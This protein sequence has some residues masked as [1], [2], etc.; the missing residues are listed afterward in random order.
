M[1]TICFLVLSV[2][3]VAT[4][5]ALEDVETVPFA[6][7][8]NSV[9][10]SLTLF[11]RRFIPTTVQNMIAGFQPLANFQ[12]DLAYNG[13]S[14]TSLF[15][16]AQSTWQGIITGD[17]SD[18]GNIC[19]SDTCGCLPCSIDD[20]RICGVYLS[21]DGTGGTLG[22]AG[23]TRWRSDTLIPY[24]GEMFFDTADVSVGNV[25]SGVILHEMAHV[26]GLGT[27]W[28]QKG[29]ASS[30]S[31][32]CTYSGAKANQ[33]YQTLSGCTGAI[34]LE[35]STG[36][37]GSDCG[38]WAEACFG[39]ELM[40]PFT[41]GLTV[42]P[43]SRVTIAGLEDLGYSVDYSKAETYVCSTSMG[44]S[45][46]CTCNS[47]RSLLDVI[48]GAVREIEIGPDGDAQNVDDNR[49]PET[50]DFKVRR[51]SAEGRSAAMS[52]GKSI[53]ASRSEERS[54]ATFSL[55]NDEG[56]AL[57]DGAPGEYIGD[58]VIS[59]FYMEGDHVYDVLVF[60]DD[61]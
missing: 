52:F 58:K 4:T 56:S 48:D 50:G 27:L 18:V 5:S 7:P 51:L 47:K 37:S 30:S 12:I 61:L 33:E 11:V 53:L 41:N 49:D 46:V 31:P 16:S 19:A 24:T 29:L 9:A 10:S 43:L 2:L 40:T 22:A 23:P 38:H 15:T 6:A 45:C 21:I 20:L 57:S 39:S 36:S 26:F 44:S 32:P 13:V 42:L 25:G 3:A 60:G 34:P 14:D 35:S 55:L 8:S 59:V 54:Y 28:T 17:V 1:R